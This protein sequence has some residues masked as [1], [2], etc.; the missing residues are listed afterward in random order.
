ME[1]ELKQLET[2]VAQLIAN[3]RLLRVE[4][5]DLHAKLV[6]AQNELTQLKENTAAVSVRLETLID[7]LPQE[8]ADGES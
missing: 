4:N 8:V 3:A 1:N 2:R 6:Q 5:Q 7:S